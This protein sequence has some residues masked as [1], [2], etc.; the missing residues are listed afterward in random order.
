MTGNRLIERR[1]VSAAGNQEHDH[2]P[3]GYGSP[4]AWCD[5]RNSQLDR[6]G[7]LWTVG[8]SGTPVLGVDPEWSAEQ[9]KREAARGEAERRKFAH[10]QGYPISADA[11][12]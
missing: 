2:C 9:R 10:R 8:P 4:Q 6:K 3:V 5:W 11:A 1:A 12:E 7:L